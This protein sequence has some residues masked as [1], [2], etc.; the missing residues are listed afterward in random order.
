MKYEVIVKMVV[1][2]DSESEA[3]DITERLI[4]EGKLALLDEDEDVL[5]EYNVDETEPIGF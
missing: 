1:F 2:A 5:Y 3:E 4:D